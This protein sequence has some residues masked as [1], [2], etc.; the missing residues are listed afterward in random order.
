MANQRAADQVFIGI[1]VSATV[2]QK[3][4]LARGGT[5]RSQWLRDAIAELLREKGFPTSVEEVSA[6]SR[7]RQPL[8]RPDYAPPISGGL[9]LNEQKP[10]K[11]AKASSKS[12]VAA[13][14]AAKK[15]ADEARHHDSK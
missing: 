8:S 11:R 2:A 13:A 12:D 15:L 7:V 1:W 4:E 5:P 3:I 10:P 9:N 14:L 6:P